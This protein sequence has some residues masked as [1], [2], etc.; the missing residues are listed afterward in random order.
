MLN[1]LAAISAG[2]SGADLENLSNE[3]AILAARENETQILKKHFESAMERI[4]G[5][6]D[7][8][9]KESSHVKLRSALVKSAETVGSWFLEMTD[10]VVKVNLVPRSK[11]KSGSVQVIRE[12]VNLQTTQ[13][14]LQRI[15]VAL[16]G[17]L[18]EEK[19]Y[20]GDISTVSNPG[21][22]KA[23]R[24]ARSMVTS[25]GMNKNFENIYLKEDEYK[26]YR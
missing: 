17:K 2:F 21:L 24:I 22:K 3:A 8:P 25:Y 14:L 9:D 10:P 12:D 15:Q 20:K 7:S 13:E 1:H 26:I 23:Y 11:Q 18:A 6:V 5:G 19:E 16:I 4:I